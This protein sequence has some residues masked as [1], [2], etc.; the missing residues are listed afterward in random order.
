[1]DFAQAPVATPVKPAP[2]KPAAA[3]PAHMQLKYPP[4]GQVKIPDVP[5]F[6]LPNGVKLYLL[7]NH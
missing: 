4:L 6:E 2:A 3:K 7:E 5:T 1:M